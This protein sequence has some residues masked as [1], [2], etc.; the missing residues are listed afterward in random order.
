MCLEIPSDLWLFSAQLLIWG[1]KSCRNLLSFNHVAPPDGKHGCT[2]CL[3]QA[4]QLDLCD[5]KSCYHLRI[6]RWT[7]LLTTW[8]HSSNQ[9]IN[10][11]YM[12]KFPKLAFSLIIPMQLPEFRCSLVGATAPDN[13]SCTRWTEVP[14]VH[15][16]WQIVAVLSDT[17]LVPLLG[18]HSQQEYQVLIL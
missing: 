13:P 5:C 10:Y 16:P 9:L 15:H 2:S 6:R 17:H 18:L 11:E 12:C 1:T 4:V 8:W 3:A 7:S 14:Q